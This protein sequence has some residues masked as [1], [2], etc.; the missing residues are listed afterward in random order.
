MPSPTSPAPPAY[1]S[2]RQ[3]SNRDTYVSEI[4]SSTVHELAGGHQDNTHTVREGGL[5]SLGR[6]AH[7]LG[8]GV[9]YATELPQ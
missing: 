7:G 6:G 9:P 2:P 8:L 3:D 4:D 5:H 1:Q